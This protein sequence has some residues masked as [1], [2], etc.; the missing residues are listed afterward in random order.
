[1]TTPAMTTAL[2]TTKATT[3]A[4]TTKV[5]PQTVSETP[6]IENGSAATTATAF[7]LGAVFFF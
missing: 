4:P 5:V 7:L 6:E 3:G 1:M 2:A